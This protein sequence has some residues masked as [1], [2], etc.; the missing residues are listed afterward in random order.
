[1]VSDFW[2]KARIHW[3]FHHG[4]AGS[5]SVAS[6]DVGFAD[7]SLTSRGS[8]ALAPILSQTFIVGPQY[9]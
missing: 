2:R 5:D 9:T 7:D 6:A 4:R 8:V 3:H 1:M